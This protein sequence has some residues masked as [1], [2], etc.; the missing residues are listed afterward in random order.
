MT[1]AAEFC[2]ALV[3]DVALLPSVYTVGDPEGVNP[4]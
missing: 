4:L 2:V 1:D 3:I